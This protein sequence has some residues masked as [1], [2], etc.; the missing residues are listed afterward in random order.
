MVLVLIAV[1]L[2][3]A[4]CGSPPTISITAPPSGTHVGGNV[5]TLHLSATGV[6]VVPANGDQSGNTAHYAV[7]VDG[8]PPASGNAITSGATVITT[9]SSQISVAGLVVGR[10]MLTAVLADGSER[11]LGS[12][13]AT[14]QVTVDGPS[15]TA[16]IV[17][18]VTSGTPFSLQLS[19]FGV[20]IA[21]IPADSSGRT[22]HYALLID[23]SLPRP[24]VIVS[25]APHMIIT[26]GSRVP[27]PTLTR[28]THVIWVVLVNGQGRTLN[29]LAAASVTVSVPK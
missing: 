5:A 17:G 18:Q 12:A 26:T 10:H 13:S 7:Y 16:Q 24:G 19:S 11:R 15:V 9:A 21:N 2:V 25:P 22:A 8:T 28:G 6:S 27:I 14:V 20:T 1:T 3:A 4:G 29:P 23:G